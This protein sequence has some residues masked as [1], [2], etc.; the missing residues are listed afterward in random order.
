[1]GLFISNVSSN[2]FSINYRFD[3][4]CLKNEC[5]LNLKINNDQKGPFY[6][7]I[8]FKNF[9]INNRKVMLSVNKIQL[10]GE[11]ITKERNKIDNINCINY[12][13][14]KDGKR[15]YKSKFENKDENEVIHPSGLN[16]LLFNDCKIKKLK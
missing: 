3:N 15:F 2:L 6:V 11:I 12:S 4:K 9:Y 1:M 5:I 16:V 8:G 10:A 7:Y 13:L 14:N